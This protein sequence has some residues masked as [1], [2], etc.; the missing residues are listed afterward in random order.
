MESTDIV[1]GV[2]GSASSWDALYWAV[3]EADRRRAQLRVVYVDADPWPGPASAGD[4]LAH[5]VTAARRL[6]PTVRITGSLATGDAVSA[7]CAA[8][9]GAALLVVGDAGR[10]SGSE[11]LGR[12]SLG[13]AGHQ[14]AAQTSVPVVVV[15]GRMPGEHRPIVVGVDGSAGA[16]A[17]IELAFTEA[18]LRECPLIAVFAYGLP[19]TAGPR[20]TGSTALATLDES[21]LPWRDKFPRVSVEATTTD[22]EPTPALVTLSRDAQLVVVG[23]HGS[24]DSGAPLGSVPR[25]VL[26]RA[27]CPVLISR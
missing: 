9:S 1:I 14:V 12:T 8:S 10:D 16:E 21:L 5:M 15:R 6:E 23:A 18:G 24:G 7:L 2:D 17:A 20:L 4:R 25:T 11:P 3:R 26:D 22:N 13:R 27:H 19:A